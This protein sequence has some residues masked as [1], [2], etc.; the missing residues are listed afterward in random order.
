[1]QLVDTP[2]T[3]TTR[4]G[5]AGR[6][7]RIQRAIMWAGGAAFVAS[8]ALCALTYTVTFGR[9]HPF[10]GWPP[11]AAD[12]ALF[13]LFALHHSL[14]ARERMKRAV[15]DAVPPRLVRSL[16]VWTASICLALMCLLWQPIG[17]N[18]YDTQGPPA[19]A[20]AV[21]QLA[22]VWLVAQSVAKIDALELAGIRPPA[23]GGLQTDGPYRLV[24]HPLYL[25][26]MLIV[27]GA[28]R[29]SGDR[30]AF[31]ALTT[32]YLVIAISWEERSLTL[33]FGDEYVRY[34]ALVRWRLIPFI[35]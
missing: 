1:M 35:Y 11:L 18:A 23:G 33:S 29:M 7:T 21:L 10:R 14:F 6:T 32:A 25:G 3:D 8:L 26:W 12:A 30:L 13:M 27:F 28:A 5:D 22:G 4:A 9:A 24:R 2:E 17:G 15:A 20:H 19:F 34:K 16:Y 31:A